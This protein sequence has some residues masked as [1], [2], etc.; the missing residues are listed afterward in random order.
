MMLLILSVEII[1]IKKNEHSF[2]TRETLYRVYHGDTHRQ[3]KATPKL[4]SVINE[5]LTNNYLGSGIEPGTS[6]V[7]VHR[8]NRWAT[9]K[10]N[11]PVYK[12]YVKFSNKSYDLVTQRWNATAPSSPV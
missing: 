8:G 3:S 6:S 12:M 10:V 11:I 1:T 7:A 4:T 5:G 9:G 2:I